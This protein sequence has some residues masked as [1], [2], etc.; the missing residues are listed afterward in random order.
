VAFS[1]DYLIGEP[2]YLKKGH[3]R[4]MVTL[5]GEI[6]RGL[7][8]KRVVVKPDNE[9]KS[10]CNALETNGYINNGEYYSINY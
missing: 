8:A 6:L 5:L 3:G 4:K 10:S 1:I 9:N 7:G 2:D